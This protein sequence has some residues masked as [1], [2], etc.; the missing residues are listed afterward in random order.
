MLDKLG[1]LA[2]E[3]GKPERL[4]ADTGYF[5]AANDL[6]REALHLGH[7]RS[8]RDRNRQ[9]DARCATTLDG[10]QRRLG[11]RASGEAVIDDNG[12]ASRRVEPRAAIQIQGPTTCDLRQFAVASSLDIGSGGAGRPSDVLID[13]D[14]WVLAVHHRAKRQLGVSGDADFADHQQIEWSIQ[15]PR[16]F[17]ADG[18]APTGKSKDDGVREIHADQP[19]REQPAGFGSVVK[20]LQFDAHDALLHHGPQGILR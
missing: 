18:H 1:A 20:T 6:V 2:E 4:L 7:Y 8:W 16:Y 5:S 14:L 13:H 10:G 11:R 17:K 19:S 12:G 9:N 3:L 15:C